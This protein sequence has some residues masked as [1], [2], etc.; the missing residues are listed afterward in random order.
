MLTKYIALGNSENITDEELCDALSVCGEHG[1]GLF[2]T[3]EIALYAASTLVKGKV[4][5]VN[6]EFEEIK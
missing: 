6:L 5:K 2:D 4:F 1:E 3:V